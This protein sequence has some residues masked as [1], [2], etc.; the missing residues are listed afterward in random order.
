MCIL[1]LSVALLLI[2]VRPI[3]WYEHLLSWSVLGDAVC[4]VCV[5]LALLS[6]RRYEIR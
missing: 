4:V 6:G 1:R 5:S 2:E 3:L